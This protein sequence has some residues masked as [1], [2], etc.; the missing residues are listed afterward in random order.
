M[1]RQIG[2]DVQLA[3]IQGSVVDQGVQVFLD[4]GKAV[5]DHEIALPVAGLRRLFLLILAPQVVVEHDLFGDAAQVRQGELALLVLGI[6]DHGNHQTQ[7]Q[8]RGQQLIQ[9][10]LHTISLLIRYRHHYSRFGMKKQRPD[11]E[12]TMITAR[13]PHKKKQK[14]TSGCKKTLFKPRNL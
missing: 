11:A 8:N 2:V 10:M 14:K 12:F 13:I 9:G 4:G 7:G 3:G 5:A 1:I 6:N